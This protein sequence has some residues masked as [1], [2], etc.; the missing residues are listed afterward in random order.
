MRGIAVKDS[1]GAYPVAAPQPAVQRWTNCV[2][3]QISRYHTPPCH[4][5]TDSFIFSAFSANCK[6]SIISWISPSMNVPKAWV[7]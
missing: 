3:K 7:V 2:T 6:A 4:Y 5:P 1:E